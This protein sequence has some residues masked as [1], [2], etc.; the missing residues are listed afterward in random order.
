MFFCFLRVAEEDDDDNGDP[1]AQVEE[2]RRK[3]RSLVERILAKLISSDI[4]RLAYK[5]LAQEPCEGCDENWPSQFD[6][7]CMAYGKSVESRLYDFVDEYYEEAA[8][9]VQLSKVMEVYNWVSIHSGAEYRYEGLDEDIASIVMETLYAWQT[10]STDLIQ[11]YYLTG[12]S[13]ETELMEECM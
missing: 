5:T 4:I 3:A 7:A 6:H 2:S 10:D 1:R 9:S 13:R 8:A 12:S 11:W